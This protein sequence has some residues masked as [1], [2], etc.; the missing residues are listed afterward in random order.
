MEQPAHLQGLASA[1]MLRVSVIIPTYNRSEYLHQA[2]ES[3]FTQSVSPFE[4][5]IVDDGST[6]NTADI[7]RV[8]GPKVRYFRQDHK[9]VSAARNLGLEVAQGEIIAWLD[10]DDLWEPNFLATLVPLLAAD[11]RLDAAY[12]GYVHIDTTG[13]ILPQ[14]SQVVVSPSELFSSL[15]DTNFIATPAIIARKRCYEQVGN[16]DTSLGMCED[17][18]MWLRFATRFIVLGLPTPMV[19]IRVHENNTLKDTTAF[20]QF[21][22]GVI[23]KHF[24]EFEGDSTT[25]PEEKKR[26]HAQTFRSIA[27]RHIQQGQRDQGW[28]F[29]EKAV[30][31][32]PA[33][34]A[35]LDTYYDLVCG[36]QPRGYRGRADLL[37]IECNGTEM[38]KWL[39]ALFSKA[40]PTFEPIR[41]AAYA[42]AYL[43]LGIVYDRAGQWT[44]ARRCLCQALGANPRLL[45]SYP[46][47]RRLIKLCTGKRLV[48]LLRMMRNGVHEAGATQ[49]A[50]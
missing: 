15:V 1:E 44:N 14:S 28:H 49:R 8:F 35:R 24:G 30:H 9:G 42:N 10:A 23:Q 31:T 6:D 4:I 48:S 17:Y 18:D 34:L 37:H 40:G 11:Q 7:V 27:L 47:A 19:K 16:F 32:W 22:L 12:C 25:W 26:A 50:H 38:L 20:A 41:H 5:I 43:A 3:I 13:N 29:L 33:L 36:D 21:R 45:A 46:F 2:L 39:N